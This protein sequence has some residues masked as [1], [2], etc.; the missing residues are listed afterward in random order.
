M[1]EDNKR[2]NETIESGSAGSD[3]SADSASGDVAA[4]T[5]MT[6]PDA[7]EAVSPLETQTSATEAVSLETEAESSDAAGSAKKKYLLALV[8]VILIVLGGIW[9]F[10]NSTDTPS[11]QAGT[12]SVT[13]NYPDVVATVNG[14]EVFKADL[15][16]SIASLGQQVQAQ[17]VDLSNPEAQ[18][19]IEQQAMVSLINARLLLQ[20]AA[21][22]DVTASDDAVTLQFEQLAT[23]LGGPEALAEQMA[24]LGLSDEKVREDIAEQLIINQYL[25]EEIPLDSL[26]VTNEEVQAFYD[27]IAAGGVELPPLED[28]AAQIAAQL[29][30]EKRQAQ[31]QVLI[32]GLRE[33][34]EIETQI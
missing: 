22:A 33:V 9:Y 13:K 21:A 28:V 8:V 24:L 4:A 1:N 18:V 19:L 17:G 29:S 16:E 7:Q 6:A 12:V 3:I 20:A 30:S 5:P 31:L 14:E 25:D 34:A 26:N 11:E 32:D 2:E 23:Q 27:E 15:I 10:L